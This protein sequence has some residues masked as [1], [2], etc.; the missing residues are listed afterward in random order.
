MK[1]ELEK[2]ARANSLRKPT[3]QV[4]LDK[5]GC[6]PGLLPRG[7]VDANG[8]PEFCESPKYDGSSTEH[9]GEDW[10]NKKPKVR[11]LLQGDIL[12]V[13]RYYQNGNPQSE[14]FFVNNAREGNSTEWYQNRNLKEKGSYHADKEHGAFERYYPNGKFKEKGTYANGMKHGIWTFY[15]KAG[16][17]KSRAEYRLDLR[18]GN[19]EF[20]DV[21][22]VRTSHGSYGRGKK[23]GRWIQ[24]Y[25]DSKKKSAG[26]YRLGMKEGKWTSYF[27]NG[28]VQA[29]TYYKGDRPVPKQTLRG[30]VAFRQ[31]D[32]LGA[33]PTV[34]RSAPLQTA[35]KQKQPK[36][37]PMTKGK[38]WQPL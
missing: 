6:P 16:R 1:S 28:K 25:A 10:P 5:S 23:D 31:G 11:Y 35:P 34:S 24:Y 17:V 36:R 8:R 4:K 19:A 27:P 33:K 32:I 13:S 29:V 2:R 7:K 38:G 26:H 20:F 18:H 3:Q 21:T 22:G 15:D 14:K 12:R 37:K 30:T 9:I